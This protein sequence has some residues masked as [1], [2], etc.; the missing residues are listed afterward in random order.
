ML[1]R[2]NIYLPDHIIHFLKTRAKEEKVTMS[3]V[4]RDVLKKEVER[5]RPNAAKSLLALAM[6]APKV[7]SNIR[8]LSRRHDYYLYIEPYEREQEKIRRRRQKKK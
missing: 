2:T 1:Q 8:D 6:R 3:D 5:E 7:R 4:V